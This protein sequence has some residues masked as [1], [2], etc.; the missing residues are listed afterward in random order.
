MKLVDLTYLVDNSS[1]TLGIPL[2]LLI[3]I[4]ILVVISIIAG[5]YK[6]ISYRKI[7]IVS[8][9]IDYLIE[10]LIYKSEFLTP[11]VEALVKLS[12]YVDLFEA[13]IKKNSDSLITYVSNNKEAVKKF[14][15]KIKDVIS[16]DKK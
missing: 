13:V 14:Q 8:K 12:S 3:L 11:T 7:S 1:N 15:K 6:I 5:I 4:G 10:D 2:W 9:K 16:I